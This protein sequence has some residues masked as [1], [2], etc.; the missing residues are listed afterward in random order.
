MNIEQQLRETLKSATENGAL[1]RRALS[2]KA[3]L[4]GGYVKGIIDGH[5]ATLA[6][7]AKLLHVLGLELTI[8][9]RGPKTVVQRAELQSAP[10]PAAVR[11]VRDP[12]LAR[13]LAAVEAHWEWLES[14]S[15]RTDFADGVYR[16]SVALGARRDGGD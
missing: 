8:S 5:S 4:N 3:R 10:G 7:A 12:E 13:L 6:N 15:A 2:L 14:A 11:L 9:K 16:T 1:S